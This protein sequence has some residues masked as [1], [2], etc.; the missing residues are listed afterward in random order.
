MKQDIS[1]EEKIEF[2]KKYTDKEF[3]GF[4]EATENKYS[5]IG[6]LSI[7][8]FFVV[9]VVGMFFSPWLVFGFLP[10][11]IIPITTMS[12]SHFKI[13]KRVDA[14]TPNLTYKDFIEMFNSN[15][16]KHI[17]IQVLQEKRNKLDYEDIDYHQNIT[18]D[19]EP[20]YLSDTNND[21]F[22]L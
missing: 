12:I 7:K 1:L 5:K 16:W 11:F 15:E 4:I 14:L 9:G 3:Q 17:A 22:M 10:G 13:K 6:L 18:I 21:E 8:I 19:D 20:F 2:Y